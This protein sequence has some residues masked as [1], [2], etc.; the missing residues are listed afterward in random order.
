MNTKLMIELIIG[1]V[2]FI[3][4]ICI[5][6]RR[7]KILLKYALLWLAASLLMIICTISPNLMHSIAD[8]IGIEIVSNMI[9]LFV[10]GINLIITFV[11][12]TIVSNQRSIITTLVE[13]IGILKEQ[14]NND[15]KI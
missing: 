7:K 3:I 8:L 11:L 2:L 6:I 12:T 13:E 14:V 1:I 15:S 4:F 9:F 10:I 5:N